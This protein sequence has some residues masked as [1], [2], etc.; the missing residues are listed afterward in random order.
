MAMGT[1]RIGALRATGHTAEALQE[2]E[3]AGRGGF[4]GGVVKSIIGPDVLLD[5]GRVEEARAALAAAA[6]SSRRTGRRF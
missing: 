3:A 6:S 5:A 4:F 2:Y 1:G